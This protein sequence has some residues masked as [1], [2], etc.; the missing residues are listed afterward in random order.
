MADPNFA[1]IYILVFLA[2]PLARIIPRLL[3]K[4]KAKVPAG[5]APA[6]QP[7]V[8]EREPPREMP[9]RKTSPGTAAPATKNDL[10]LGVLNRGARSFDGIQKK[11]GLDSKEL[12][13]ILGA[14]ERDGLMRVVHKGGILGPKTELHPTEEGFKRFYSQG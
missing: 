8:S 10:V 12:D 7:E 11:T 13:E 9:E 2:I 3:A 6:P 5:A 4:G 1:W 14:L